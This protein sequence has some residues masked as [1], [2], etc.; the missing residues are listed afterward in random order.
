MSK[1]VKKKATV[2]REHPARRGSDHPHLFKPTV[3]YRTC[4]I[5]GLPR[6]HK[7][8]DDRNPPTSDLHMVN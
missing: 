3:G 7:V 4:R 6:S 8:H 5:C 1:I 2:V